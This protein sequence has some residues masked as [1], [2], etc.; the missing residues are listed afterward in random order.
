MPVRLHFP[1]YIHC[2]PLQKTGL[3]KFN[4]ELATECDQLRAFDTDGRKWSEQNYPGGYTSYASMN[5]LHRF[6]S[7]F[8]ALERKLT[9]HVKAYA[10][11]LDFDLRGADVHMTDCW[12]NMMP[13]GTTHG[14]H[15]H[16]LSFISGT[17][18]VQ[19]PGGCPGIKFEDPRLDRFMAAPP[20]RAKVRPEN[21]IFVT[22]PAEAGNVILFESWLRHE[23]PANQ[24]TEERISISFNY[25][26]R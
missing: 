2:E 5:Q 9:K 19:T 6:S 16:P 20:R 15:L 7:T 18:Y 4:D 21:E 1:T 14:L 26:W 12:V 13:P 3:A 10:K 25:D 23:V 11:A 8:E 24:V 17:Y 22:Y